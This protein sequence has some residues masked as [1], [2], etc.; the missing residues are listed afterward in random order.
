MTISVNWGTKIIYVPRTDM[1]LL[2]E[3]PE[4]R[5]L[6]ENVFRLILRNLEDGE[7]GMGH[8]HTH[9]HDTE[10]LLAGVLFAR[11][12]KYVNGYT[13][14]FEDGQYAVKAVGANSNLAD[15]VNVNQVSLR[16]SPSA[17]LVSMSTLVDSVEATR[18]DVETWGVIAS[19]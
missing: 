17:G 4:I 7:D 1:A 13:V 15:V 11:K 10:V 3:T 5:E 2:Q 6:D 12:I 18:Q 19:G 16:T 8:L 14:T 9:E